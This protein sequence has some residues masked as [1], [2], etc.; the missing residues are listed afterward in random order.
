M[1]CVCACFARVMMTPI[2]KK[3]DRD[4]L[5]DAVTA[6][7][8][9]REAALRSRMPQLQSPPHMPSRM[10]HGV[11]AAGAMPSCCVAEES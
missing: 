8:Q 6:G 7:Q 1:A 11:P 5:D 4:S 10:W 9:P 3:H 2:R